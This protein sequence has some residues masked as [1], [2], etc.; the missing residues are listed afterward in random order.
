MGVCCSSSNIEYKNNKSAFKSSEVSTNKKETTININK[1]N[2]KDSNFLKVTATENKSSP[3][4]INLRN[5]TNLIDSKLLKINTININNS[6]LN[7]N[8]KEIKKSLCINKK[9][10]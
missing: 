1:H 6:N 3:Q 2:E 5:N 4:E 9:V 8:T 10:R 7:F